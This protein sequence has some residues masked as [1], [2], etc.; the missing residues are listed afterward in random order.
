MTANSAKITTNIVE[1]RPPTDHSRQNNDEE[2]QN[3]DVITAN[4]VKSRQGRGEDLPKTA[5]IAAKGRRNSSN[6]VIKNRQDIQIHKIQARR[7]QGRVFSEV[8]EEPQARALGTPS[9]KKRRPMRDR[10]Y[11]HQSSRG[12]FFLRSA[13]SRRHA[14]LGTPSS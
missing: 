1:D 7:L 6:M 4:S 14:P 5:E 3:L 8:G 12:V 2:R 11:I 10:R 9:S 13:K